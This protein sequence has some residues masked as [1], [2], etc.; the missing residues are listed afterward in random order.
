[1]YDGKYVYAL[2]VDSV[3]LGGTKIFAATHGGIYRSTN[4]GDSW[5]RVCTEEC[6]DLTITT[7]SNHGIRLHAVGPWGVVTS[8]DEDSIWLPATG[9]NVLRPFF[10][11]TSLGSIL[12][13]NAGSGVY[14]STDFGENW[15]NIGLSDKEVRSL[16]LVP[17]FGGGHKILVGTWNGLY[18]S[19]N[20]GASWALTG[21]SGMFVGSIAVDTIEAAGEMAYKVYAGTKYNGVWVSGDGGVNWSQAGTPADN[22]TC[23]AFLGGDAGAACVFAG[24]GMDGVFRST[25]DGGSWTLINN[26]STGMSVWALAQSSVGPGKTYLFAG[27]SNGVYRSSDNGDHWTP[28]NNGLVDPTSVDAAEPLGFALPQ[29]YPNPFNPTTVISCQLPVA[30][31]VR[32]AVYD[33]LGREVAVL[34]DER[35][36]AGR[37]ELKFDGSALSSGVYLLRMV[38][39]R[40]IATQKMMLVR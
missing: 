12:Y 30:G 22:I 2:L 10:R 14:S 37:Y 35:K 26:G 4:Y 39:G 13:A 11:I 7:D 27:T 32:L 31:H 19:S 24:G 40:F 17:T 33:L 9:S 25:N 16:A 18:C 3:G 38:A 6:F 15:V 1:M 5:R 21:M 34:V 29:N 23:F 20:R 8:T 36:E 28:V